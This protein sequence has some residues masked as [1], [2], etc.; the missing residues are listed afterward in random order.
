[1]DVR[2]LGHL[3]VEVSGEPVRFEGVKQRRLFAVLALRAPDAVSAV[4]VDH[5]QAGAHAARKLEGGDACTQSEGRERVPEI[6]DA[7]EGL[8]AGQRL[9]RASS[10]GF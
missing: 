9:G 1:M 6:G 4:A 8:D 7:A 2:L 3:E 5:G 10:C